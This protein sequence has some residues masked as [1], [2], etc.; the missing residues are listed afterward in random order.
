MWIELHDSGGALHI[1]MDNVIS[2]R[3][4]DRNE[5]TQVATSAVTQDSPTIFNVH[6][7]PQEIENMIVDEQRR[8][9]SLPQTV[10]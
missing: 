7:T 8:L 10:R 2:F 5:L 4:H 6:E 3:R 1:N 9:A